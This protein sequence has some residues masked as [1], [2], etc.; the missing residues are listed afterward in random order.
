M[1]VVAIAWV[2]VLVITVLMLLFLFSSSSLPEVFQ[3]AP[4]AL[5]SGIPICTTPHQLPLHTKVHPLPH[6]QVEM[7][8]ATG[9][10]IPITYQDK[11]ATIYYNKHKNDV[12]LAG[13]SP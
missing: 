6:V 3:N 8:F 12:K 2:V 11:A 5:P 13:L 1:C 9:E 7:D 4:H 10:P